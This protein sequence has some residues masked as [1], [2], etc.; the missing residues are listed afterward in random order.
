MDERLSLLDDLRSGRFD[1]SVTTTY[2]IDFHFYE[3]VVLRRLVAAGCQ[4]HVLLV[5]AIRCAEALADPD[6]RP[7]LAGVA[8][9]LVPVR[10]PGAFH[11]KLSIL[12]GKKGAK[13]FVGS[14]NATF[15]GFGGNAEL[16]TR[17]AFAASQV[18]TESLTA[19]ALRAVQHWVEPSG[20]AVALEAVD[21]ALRAIGRNRSSPAGGGPTLLW[22]GT[23]RLPLWDQLRTRLPAQVDRVVVGGPFFDR[24]LR[25]LSTVARELR[26]AELIVA[27]D[28]SAVVL[29]VAQANAFDAGF[30]DIRGLL[31]RVAFSESTPLHAKFMLIEGGGS[32]ILVTGSANPSAA[33]WLDAGRNA[34]A[35]TVRVNVPNQELVGLGFA[36][37]VD[38]PQITAAQWKEI[39]ER[40]QVALPESVPQVR[41]V[42][43]VEEE[44][45][46][47]V[48]G[49]RAEP[50]RVA[51]H[52][53]RQIETHAAQWIAH[54][55][56]L[57]VSTTS[58]LDLGTC[59]LVELVG[60]D[61]AF[62]VVDHRSALAPSGGESLVQADLRAAMA[63]V[64]DDPGQLEAAMRI[65]ERAIFDDDVNH[66]VRASVAHQGGQVDPDVS[67]EP[68]GPRMMKLGEKTTGHAG[69]RRRSIAD[70]NISVV[71]DLLIRKLSEG[72]PTHKPVTAPEVEERDLD[73]IDQSL[74]GLPPDLD[75]DALMKACHRKVRRLV[76]RMVERL[77][78][79]WQGGDENSVLPAIVQLAA[80]LGVLRWLMRV[81]ARLPWLPFGD[82]LVPE[83]DRQTLFWWASTVLAPSPRSLVLRARRQLGEQVE[84]TSIVLGLLPWLGWEA[85]VDV[86]KL[87][88]HPDEHEQDEFHWVGRLLVVLQLTTD[89]SH[90]V[91]VLREAV[92]GAKQMSRDGLA[93][94]SFHVALSE[95]MTL[96]Q[97]DPQ[98]APTLERGVR[99]GDLVLQEMPDGRAS[100]G[101]VAD[102]DDTKVRITD[103]ERDEGRPV[104]K[105]FVRPLDVAR[106][107]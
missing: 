1:V 59:D 45:I 66:A 72:L 32:T 18:G 81:Q 100:V 13:V 91:D 2:S 80:V 89:D 22:S 46:I 65:V 43:A 94:L 70:G 51:L 73:P 19:E 49:L 83:D 62:A 55:G 74:R 21:T 7:R 60:A 71:M 17:C 95:A 10:Y 16:T 23:A 35:V 39:A 102:V 68:L 28:P 88:Q 79:A 93:W 54:D 15:A 105:K 48:R 82:S 87:Q 47:L 90:A 69:K 85:G 41:A 29:D 12:A 106:L 76:K 75:A 38:A 36:S 34:E 50:E 42:T 67:A 61:S 78:D 101:F 14:H 37:L 40:A 4:R 92:T 27:I 20:S 57:R 103:P 77:D 26:P 53:R 107:T 8:Y 52:C 58:G 97:V 9:A 24:A 84:E 104:L 44:G 96:A 56:A 64:S 30:V 6:L 11:P 63:G 31:G 3:R 5:D 98:A 86:R 99:R 25:F 33:A